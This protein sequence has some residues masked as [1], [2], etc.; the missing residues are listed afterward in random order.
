MNEKSFLKNFKRFFGIAFILSLIIIILEVSSISFF[1]S[2]ISERVGR[3]EKIN[4][5]IQNKSN[6]LETH[7]ILKKELEEAKNLEKQL[8]NKLASKD[9]L[10]QLSSEL[11]FLAKASGV[12]VN[13]SFSSEVK[14]KSTLLGSVGVSISAEGKLPDIIKFLKRLEDGRFLVKFD[15]FDIN[16]V[17]QELGSNLR[18][19]ARGRVV[20][21]NETN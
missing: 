18:L 17:S 10:L 5:D 15:N 11:G 12:E 16:S 3:M 4:R 7:F 1:K 8:E 13:A 6:I 9:D 2:N 19:F 21:R 20:Y 14:E